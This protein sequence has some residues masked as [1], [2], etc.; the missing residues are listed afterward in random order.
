MRNRVSWNSFHRM[1]SE[2]NAEMIKGSIN[3]GPY[4]VLVF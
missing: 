4:S 2:F 3:L 1:E